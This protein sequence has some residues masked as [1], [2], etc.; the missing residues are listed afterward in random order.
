MKKVI[1]IFQWITTVVIRPLNFFFA[2][3]T[4]EGAH[5]LENIN[6]PVIFIANHR[7]MFDPWILSTSLPIKYLKKFLPFRYA[8]GAKFLNNPFLRPFLLI[9]GCFP[10]KPK[11]GGIKEAL[12]PAIEVLK[13]KKQSIVF[14][15]EGELSC[16][17]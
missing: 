4:V 3:I 13:D 5:F 6:G 16:V 7:S 2:S 14:F 12:K 17:K 11:S 9:Y 8:T 10:I 15:P 1:I